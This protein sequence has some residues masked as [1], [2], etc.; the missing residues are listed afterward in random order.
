MEK[1][2]QAW[3]NYAMNHNYDG[4]HCHWLNNQKS[5]GLSLLFGEEKNKVWHDVVN[6][7]VQ[8]LPQIPN[9]CI[10]IFNASF[11]YVQLGDIDLQR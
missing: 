5:F 8:K 4:S 2:Q 7:Y 9:D 10:T 11:F 6:T 1:N 3:K